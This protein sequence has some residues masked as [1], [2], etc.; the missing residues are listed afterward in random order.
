MA[1]STPLSN[2]FSFHKNKVNNTN[3]NTNNNNSTTFVKK[4][5][6]HKDDKHF[7]IISIHNK[8]K[9]SFISPSYQ[10][11]NKNKLFH[12]NFAVNNYE[13][14]SSKNV[15]KN[16]IKKLKNKF[17]EIKKIV[18]DSSVKIV[19]KKIH[20]IGN[21]NDL[22]KLLNNNLSN[23]F[24]KQLK[25]SASNNN[26]KK[27]FNKHKIIM[28]LQHIKFLPN[29]NYSKTL[30]ELYKSKKNL[31]I[32]LVYTDSIQRYIFRGLYEVNSTDQKTANKLFAPGY[33]QN[34]INVNRLNSFF[35]YQSN[36]G[37]FVKI[38]F[39]NDYDKKF[40]S[41]TIIVY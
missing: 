17:N 1:K 7:H 10:N 18:N 2:Y 29:E 3:S 34:V 23:G 26:L 28:A 24:N 25:G 13:N 30:N 19:H 27:N 41:D 20:T 9:T 40:S 21:S 15:K 38:K 37:E 4:N 31:F 12:K 16:H 33:G 32:I 8:S 22:T 35:N 11:I 5:N 39:N 36:N 6:G 14:K